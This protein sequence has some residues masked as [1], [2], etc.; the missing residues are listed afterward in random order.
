MSGCAALS[1]PRA[2]AS[3]G[4]LPIIRLQVAVATVTPAATGRRA[5]GPRAIK[6]PIATPEAGQK[7][8]TPGS[9]RSAKPRRPTRKYAMPVAMASFTRPNHDWL[10]IERE[11]STPSPSLRQQLQLNVL[12]VV[13]A[14]EANW[15]PTSIGYSTYIV[16]WATL[17]FCH[18]AKPASG[19]RSTPAQS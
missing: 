9:A 13:G 7:T 10:T 19:Q 6:A 17:S 4:F 15:R 12:L 18:D 2:I 5:P 16:L 14:R 8:A 3:H 1:K 11:C